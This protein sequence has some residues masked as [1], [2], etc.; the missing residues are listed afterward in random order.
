LELKVGVFVFLGLII[1]VIFVL[2]IGRFKTWTSGYEVKFVFNF[3]NGIKVGGPVRFAGLDVG[4]VKKINFIPPINKEKTSIEIV[5]WVRR[6]VRIPIDSTIWV[7][8]LGLL[9]EKYIEIMPGKDYSHCMVA[10]DSLVGVD[11]IPMHEVVRL[12]KDIT[13][14]IDESIVKIK[15]KE[16]TLGKLIYEDTIYNELEAFVTDIRKHPWKLFR[17]TKEKPEKK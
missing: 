7:N 5:C 14:N 12:A 2:S 17:V 1:L 9:G 4:E 8:T 15:N 13:E 3:V 10:N 11:P 6:D 16:G